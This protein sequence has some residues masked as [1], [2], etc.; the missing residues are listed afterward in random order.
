MNSSHENYI[1][2]KE[3]L[4]N[5]VNDNKKFEERFSAVLTNMQDFIKKYGCEN[6]VVINELSLGYMLVDYFEDVRRLKL[7]HQIDHI[8]SVKVVAYISYWILRRKPIQVIALDKNL[9]YI[10]ER[11]VLAY[12]LN[13]L[14]SKEKG[15]LL[16]RENTGLKSFVKSLY[17]F[18]KYRAYSAQSIELFLM[19]FFAGKIYQETNEDLSDFLPPSDNE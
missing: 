11:Y 14:S 2:A 6:K 10:N 19:S 18:L 1:R 8:N 13:F 12:I 5:Y 17:Y 16:V 4:K 9:L 3:I 7:F 15:L